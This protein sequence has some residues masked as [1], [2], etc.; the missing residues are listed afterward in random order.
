LVQLERPP[1]LHLQ[2]FPMPRLI[3]QVDSQPH[4]GD[5]HAHK[6]NQPLSSVAVSSRS[7]PMLDPRHASLMANRRPS[8]LVA[9]SNNV[10]ASHGVFTDIAGD[11]ITLTSE[12]FNR[13]TLYSPSNRYCSRLI[14][15]QNRSI[16]SRQATACRGCWISS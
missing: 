3:S 4:G 10:N 16:A 9:G 6:V 1:Y 14:V 8:G 13:T 15:F 5:A 7:V 11:Q 12:V 2:P